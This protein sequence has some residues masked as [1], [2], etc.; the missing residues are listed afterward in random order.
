MNNVISINHPPLILFLEGTLVSN[1][2]FI[3]NDTQFPWY[4]A[5][6]GGN[7]TIVT[8]NLK[9]EYEKC[10]QVTKSKVLPQIF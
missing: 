1:T 5:I 8:N 7:S 10:K 9:Q 4:R 3:V 2:M 6:I